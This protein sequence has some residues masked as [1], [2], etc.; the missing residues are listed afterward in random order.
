MMDSALLKKYNVPGPRYTS[1]PTV[2]YWD[3]NPSESQWIQALKDSLES[4]A[5]TGMGAAIYAHIPFCESLCT[6]CG[7]NTRITRNHGASDPYIDTILKEFDLYREKLGYQ[8]K[9]LL[10]SELHLGGGTPTFFTPKELSRFLDGILAQCEVTSDFEFS[11]EVDPR[12]TSREHLEVLREHQF[13][14][15]SLGIQDFDPKVQDIVHRIQSVAQVKKITD[16]SRELGFTSIN[17]DLIYGLP[18]QTLSSVEGT[19]QKVVELRPD[20]IAF[21]AYAHVPWIKPGQR[22]FT[23]ADLPSGDEKRALYE[24]GRELLENAGYVEIGMDH[25]AL[26]SDSLFTAVQNRALHRNFMGY[27][28]R[29]VN[30]ILALGVSAIGDAWSAFA[31]NE[32]LLETYVERVTQ[33]EIPIYRGHV[34]NEED[35]ILRKHVLNLMTSMHTTWKN[36]PESTPYLSEVPGKLKE[37]EQDGLVV[38]SVDS[39]TVTEKGRAFLRNI[40]MAL[41]ARLARKAPETR[42]FSQTV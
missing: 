6:Y 8:S 32:K 30:P 5:K 15:V 34:L 7:C 35:L 40:C 25:F 20:R 13:K 41:D 1:Y 3:T 9:K 36:E 26:K 33:G 23:E 37:L 38:L 14:R 21:Y 4:A 12:V 42:L 19:I 27:T 10:L 31:Q 16:E 39:C 28:A 11:I 2:P 24:R 18:L 22:R 17:Y 29:N